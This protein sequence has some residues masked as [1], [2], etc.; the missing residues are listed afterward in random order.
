MFVSAMRVVGVV[1]LLTAL[2]TTVRADD[3]SALTTCKAV[4]ER[5]AQEKGAAGVK[6]QAEVER[7]RIV[8]REWTLRDS[9]MLVDEQ[10]QPQR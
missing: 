3:R 10:G 7:C 6:D 9:R 8:I 5:A 4:M 1:A 2:P